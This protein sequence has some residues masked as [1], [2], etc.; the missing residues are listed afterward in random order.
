MSGPTSCQASAAGAAVLE[1]QQYDVSGLMEVL[2]KPDNAD[3]DEVNR[4][5]I[6]QDARHQQDENSSDERDQWVE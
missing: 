1:S 2:R 4:D 6:V 3:G 5:D